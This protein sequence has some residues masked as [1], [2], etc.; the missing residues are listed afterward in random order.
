VN[1]SLLWKKKREDLPKPNVVVISD[2]FTVKMG[3]SD[4]FCDATAA[5]LVKIGPNREN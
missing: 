1:E 2:D 3:S 4:R 5:N